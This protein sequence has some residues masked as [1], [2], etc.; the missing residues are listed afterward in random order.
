[1]CACLNAKGVPESVNGIWF[2]KEAVVQFFAIE[3]MYLSIKCIFPGAELTPLGWE[4]G[5]G[6]CIC[7]IYGLGRRDCKGYQWFRDS[8]TYC[9]IVMPYRVFGLSSLLSIQPLSLSFRP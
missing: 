3:I 8:T 5:S 1:M 9:R 7:L 4:P 6:V 2:K